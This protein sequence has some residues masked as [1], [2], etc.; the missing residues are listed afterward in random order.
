MKRSLL[1]FFALAGCAGNAAAPLPS[2]GW[3]NPQTLNDVKP[4]LVTAADFKWHVAGFGEAGQLVTAHCGDKSQWRV[5]AGGA[6]SN[7][8]SA[9]GGGFPTVKTNQWSALP[10]SGAKGRV[11]LSCARASLFNHR[12]LI[13][14]RIVKAINGQASA[15]C[16]SGYGLVSGS[17]LIT[18]SGQKITKTFVD[19][20]IPPRQYWVFG[21]A[22]VQISCGRVNAVTFIRTQAND[23]PQNVFAA[24]PK[25]YTVIGGLTGIGYWPYPPLQSHPGAPGQPGNAGFAGWWIQ[26]PKDQNYQTVV[27]WAACVLSHA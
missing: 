25:G 2:S 23:Q 6:G 22:S 7:D 13:W 15:T 14:R 24:C 9:I 1:L 20:A 10:Q 16:P 17:A 11:Y 18:S 19:N 8:G 5:V 3:L 26:A 12:T 4:A 21:G 27:S